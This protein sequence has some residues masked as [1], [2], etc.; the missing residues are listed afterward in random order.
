MTGVKRAV[1]FGAGRGA[2]SLLALKPEGFQF[3]AVVDNDS[4]IWGQSIGDFEIDRP[5]RLP[6]LDFDCLVVSTG[7]IHEIE[8]QLEAEFSIPKSKIFFPPK[9]WL[10][11][12]ILLDVGLREFAETSLSSLFSW[13]VQN[14]VFLMPQ[15]G[16]LLGIVRSGNLIPWDNDVDLMVHQDHVEAVLHQFGQF[17]GFGL[18][19]VVHESLEREHRTVP[20]RV[21][22]SVQ[23]EDRALPVSIDVLIEKGDE[24]IFTTPHLGRGSYRILSRDLF[25]PP[26]I[27]A[28]RGNPLFIPRQVGQYLEL[29]YGQDWAVP[30]PDWTYRN[31]GEVDLAGLPNR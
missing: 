5:S 18:V 22:T 6:E 2:E 1:I 26:R 9:A 20:V 11:G 12:Q 8:S 23:I 14:G 30:R 10:A 19:E 24:V 21:E 29:L 25:L 7:W 4:C 13:S 17:G 16:T 27:E 31:H 3:I 28:W 15:F